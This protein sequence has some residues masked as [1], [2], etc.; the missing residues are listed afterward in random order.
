M[1]EVEEGTELEGY[2]A[3]ANLLDAA[4]L[5]RLFLLCIAFLERWVIS[6]L[7]VVR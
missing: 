4:L 7:L 1:V 5:R 3:E 6:T 2:S